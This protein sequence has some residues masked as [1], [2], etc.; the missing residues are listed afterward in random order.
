MRFAYYPGCTAKSSST[1]YDESIRVTSRYLEID[2]EEIPGWTCCGA[3]SGHYINHEL[4]L[5]LPSRNLALAE[6]MSL[7]IVTPCPACSLR[8]KVAEYELKNNMDLKARIERDIGRELK[9]SRN[10]KHILEVLYHDVGPDFISKKVQKPLK[11]LKT[12]MYYGCYLVR[13]PEITKFDDPE[14]PVIMDKIMEAL[15]VSVIDWSCKVDCCGGGLS[16]TSPEIVQK[17]VGKIVGCAL[18]AGA[19]AIITACPMCQINLDMRQPGN[20]NPP[21]VPIFYF[22]ELTALAFGSL[23]IK[24]WLGKHMVDPSSLLERLELYP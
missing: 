4:A 17:L 21:P 24:D 10:T 13:P 14:N 16:L 9:L 7:D 18:E 3:S 23:H 6:K 8:H 19:E 11:G 5:A 15:G 22:S 20:E 12:A 2:L 1:E